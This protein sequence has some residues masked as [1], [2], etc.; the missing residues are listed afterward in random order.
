MITA[1]PDTTLQDGRAVCV[2]RAHQILPGDVVVGFEAIDLPV[3]AV[4]RYEDQGFVTA[5][6]SSVVGYDERTYALQTFVSITPRT[7]QEA[8]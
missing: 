2:I 1:A 8:H 6:Y 7:E 5:C 3:V 4:R